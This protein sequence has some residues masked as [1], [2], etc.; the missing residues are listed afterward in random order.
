[1]LFRAADRLDQGVRET[2]QEKAGI[3]QLLRRFINSCRCG[4]CGHEWQDQWSGTC[5]DDCP[6]C[7][8]GEYEPIKSIELDMA[9]SSLQDS[10][11]GVR[12]VKITEAEW[13]ERFEPG[14]SLEVDD[15]EATKADEHLIWTEVDDSE[16]DGFLIYPGRHW[17]KRVGYFV[18]R[19]P[20]DDPQILVKTLPADDDCT[21]H[22]FR[23]GTMG[24][25]ARRATSSA[26]QIQMRK[27]QHEWRKSA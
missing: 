21:D 17:V 26:G 2:P 16:G 27:P 3:L 13:E 20:W 7:G 5:N 24:E 25:R 12:H 8:D 23:K 9:R 10:E 22:G 11:T 6:C 15:P 1:M 18:C 4:R 19:H 14:V